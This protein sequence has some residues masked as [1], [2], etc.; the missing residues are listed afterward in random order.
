M[1]PDAWVDSLFARM[2]VR[3]GSS[4]SAKW[5]G[6]DMAAVRADWAAELAGF[7]GWPEAISYGLQ[8]IPA[9]R[10]P[11]VTQFRELCRGAPA[12]RPVLS[13]VPQLAMSDELIEHRREEV[14]AKLKAVREKLTGRSAA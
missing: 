10:P 6:L 8:Y 4:W 2:A 12:R 11:T 14:R 13:A 1:L 7:A 5:E 9:D 3:Y